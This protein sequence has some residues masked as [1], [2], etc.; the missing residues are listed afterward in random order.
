MGA[1]VRNHVLFCKPLRR[2]VL[3]QIVRRHAKT[4]KSLM[5]ACGQV[6]VVDHRKAAVGLLNFLL[7]VGFA[8]LK[9]EDAQAVGSTTAEC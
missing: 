6:G 8:G 1:Y 5:A 9:L 3:H 2:N 4:N 7:R